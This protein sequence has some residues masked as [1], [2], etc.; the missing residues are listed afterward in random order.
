MGGAE[1]K[2]DTTL[3]VLLPI[4]AAGDCFAKLLTGAGVQ[5]LAVTHDH[6]VELLLEQLLGGALGQWGVRA[7]DLHNPNPNPTQR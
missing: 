1:L 7:E 4:V 5:E 6:G 3:G 2:S